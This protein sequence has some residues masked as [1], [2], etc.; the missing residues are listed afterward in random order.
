MGTLK[1]GSNL[2]L[3]DSDAIRRVNHYLKIGVVDK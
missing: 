2:R 3:A 1:V